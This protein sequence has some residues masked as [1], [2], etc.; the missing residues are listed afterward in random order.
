MT[1][2][3]RDFAAG[4]AAFA[5]G[6]CACRPD[7]A[8]YPGWKPGELDIHF[9]HTGVGEQT[10][11]IFPDGTTMLLDCGDTHHR[12]YMGE[13]P[14]QPGA[15]RLGGEWTS[16]YIQRL[17]PARA[18]DY[19]MVSHW[20]GDHIGDPSLGFK[21]T[22][23]GRRVVGITAVAED[24]RFRRYFDH[25]YPRTGQY[26]MD[27]DPEAFALFQ[28]WLARARADGLEVRPFRVGARDQ[29]A[30]VKD[31]ARYPSF[32]VRNLCANAVLWDGADG[33]VDCGAAHVKATGKKRIHENRLSAAIRVD[34]GPFSYY[35]G[36]DAELTLVGADGKPF[37]YEEAIGRACGPVDVAKTNHHAGSHGMSAAFCREIR[38]TVYLSS[39]WQAKMVDHV[40]LSSMCSRDLYP[41]ERMVCF[42]WIADS[43]KP[44]AA[45]YGADIA[46]AGHAVVKVAP[47]GGTYRVYTLSA[48]DESMRV[49]GCR[50][51]VS[52]PKPGRAG[53][54]A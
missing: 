49:L 8:V 23:D 4:A 27:P 30:L 18:I 28:E 15:D 37:N 2:T 17:V 42:G 16:R 25:Q 3:R 34:Y 35:T 12:K 43:V 52:S 20:H 51:F 41:G 32:S 46:P 39:V 26:A 22:P 5:L 31:P 40:S 19:L 36:G 13:V 53:R 14:P 33:T 48:A 21:K 45:A 11:F 1:V 44:V 29:I 10:F 24:F 38:A 54:T 6:G 7:A 50:D 47:G 9:I